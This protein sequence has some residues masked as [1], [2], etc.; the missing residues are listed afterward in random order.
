[1]ILYDFTW[2]KQ[3]LL[4]FSL[5]GSAFCRVV[6]PNPPIDEV[7]SSGIVPKLIEFLQNGAN[8]MLQVK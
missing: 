5:Q 6:E 7:I 1:M 3:I 2:Y 4:K 8:S